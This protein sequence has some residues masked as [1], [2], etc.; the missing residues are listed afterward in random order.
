M[1][2]GTSIAPVSSKQANDSTLKGHVDYLFRSEPGTRPA[3]QAYLVRQEQGWSIPPHF[4]L[5]DQ[6]QLVVG[7]SGSIGVHLVRRGALHFASRHSGYGPVAAG[8]EGLSYLTL[9]AVTDS[10]LWE[11]PE[12][13]E[14]NLRELPK[15]Q[16]T[17]QPRVCASGELDQSQESLHVEEMIPPDDSGLG[18]WFLSNS[19]AEVVELP[20]QKAAGGRFIYVFEGDFTDGEN[21]FSAGSCLWLDADEELNLCRSGTNGLQLC[22]AQFPRTALEPVE[23]LLQTASR[24]SHS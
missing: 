7:G 23:S 4:H 5:E 13:R 16:V 1:K 17:V 9:R 10:Y 11:L 6:Y 21:E 24:H 18:A 12:N 19:K 14:K 22:I 20:K 2:F 15:R 3:P 8:P